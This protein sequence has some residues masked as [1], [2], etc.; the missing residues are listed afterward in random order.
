MIRY[1]GHAACLY[2]VRTKASPSE[3][4]HAKKRRQRSARQACVLARMRYVRPC[5]ESSILLTQWHAK[6]QLR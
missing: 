6:K 5:W 4:W 2:I 1:L 3:Q